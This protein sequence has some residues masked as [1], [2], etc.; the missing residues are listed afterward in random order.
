MELRTAQA[1]FNKII[2]ESA[3][4]KLWSR[5]WYS[6]TSGRYNYK[7]GNETMEIFEELG[8]EQVSQ[9]FYTTPLVTRENI[10]AIRTT[11]E[12]K[13]KELCK[14]FGYFLRNY[15]TV[16]DIVEYTYIGF[17]TNSFCN[18][19][20]LG[21]DSWWDPDYTNEVFKCP[22]SETGY[23]SPVCRGWYKFQYANPK[24][25]TMGDLYQYANGKLFG[26][27][28]CVPLE[29]RGEFYGALC[30]DIKVSQPLIPF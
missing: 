5:E 1:F 14:S 26:I 15:L 29:R 3:D 20:V 4:V 8:Q 13:D 25:A 11:G 16:S 2:D 6:S 28:F 27:T 7:H 10:D 19:P 24:L 17:E 30:Y 21:G 22:R 9:Y 18:A 23:Y 12:K